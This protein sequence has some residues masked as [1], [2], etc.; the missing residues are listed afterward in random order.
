V[1]IEVEK[2]TPAGEPFAHTYEPGELPLEEERLRLTGPARIEGRASRKE[3]E[4]R[5]RGR[6]AAEAEVLC[7]RCLK[8]VLAPLEVEFET[9]FVPAAAEAGKTE[10]VELLAEELGLAAYEGD[11]VNLDE[12]VRE[13][14]LLAVPTR[15]LCR[16]ECRGLCPTCGADLNEGQCSCAQTETDPRWAAL[17]DWKKERES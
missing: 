2:L 9:A 8:P 7:D 11:A 16:E 6:I 5:L 1:R 3:D 13:Q 4:V 12:L 10:N 15:L 14:I 17:A